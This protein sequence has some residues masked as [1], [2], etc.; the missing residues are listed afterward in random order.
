[1]DT[2]YWRKSLALAKALVTVPGDAAAWARHLPAWGRRPLDLELPWWSYGAIRHFGAFLQSTHRVF[3]FGSGGSSLFTARRAATVLSVEHDPA[4]HR[5][6]TGLARQRGLGNLTCELHQLAD[7]LLATFQNSPFCQ[8][9]TSGSWDAI[10]IDCHCGFQ[11]GPYGVIRPAAFA[12]ALPQV[13]PGGC[14]VLD[15]SWMY[16]ELLR[17]RPGWSIRDYI[18]TG[19]CRYGVTSTAVFRRE[20]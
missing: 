3:E 19:P 6:V 13:S 20:S 10:I 8:R 17:P 16:P 9:V 15:D 14:I 4:W 5:L 7:D 18:G 11:A 12:A 2:S 1:M